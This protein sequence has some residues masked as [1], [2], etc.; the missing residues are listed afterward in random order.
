MEKKTNWGEGSKKKKKSNISQD[1][2]NAPEIDLQGCHRN[3]LK[4]WT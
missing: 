4:C 3:L 2:T 1:P